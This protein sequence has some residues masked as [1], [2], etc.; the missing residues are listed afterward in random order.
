MNSEK[1]S[2]ELSTKTLLNSISFF[3]LVVSRDFLYSSFCT[4]ITALLTYTIYKNSESVVFLTDVSGMICSNAI[5]I[6]STLLAIIIAAIAIF[7]SFSRPQL[8]FRL[9]FHKQNE[10]RLHQ[11]LSV[12]IF[13]ALPA[14]FGIFF[15][16]LGNILMISKNN[17]AIIMAFLALFFT[18]Y[19]IFGIWE[20]IKQIAKSVVTLAKKNT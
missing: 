19:C 13:P 17:Y 8:L 14:I 7:T 9:Y 1:Q 4:L 15:G 11:Y 5:N 2:N 20:S 3:E 10:N 6:N 12:L 18:Y 16:I